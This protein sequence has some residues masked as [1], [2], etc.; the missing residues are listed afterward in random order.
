MEQP[1]GTPSSPGATTPAPVISAT[2]AWLGAQPAFDDKRGRKLGGAALVSIVFH[3]LVIVG[4]LSYFAARTDVGQQIA[5]E[6]IKT[7]FL[8]VPGPGGGGGGS[9]A[10]APKKVESIPPHKAPAPVPV[11]TPQPVIPPPMLNAPVI[12]TNATALQAQ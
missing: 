9:P 3:A 7:V 5:N 6:V 8:P 2:G 4:L 10:P 11:P 12:T 1:N